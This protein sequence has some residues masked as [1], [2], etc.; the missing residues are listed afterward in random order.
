MDEKLIAVEQLLSLFDARE[1]LLFDSN[2]HIAELLTPHALGAL[3][4][5]F[6]LPHDNVVWNHFDVIDEVLIVQVTVTYVPG[7]D[8]SEFLS[9]VAPS[10]AT[11]APTQVEKT[12]QFGIPL[13][14]AV[15]DKDKLKEWLVR[16]STPNTQPPPPATKEEPQ[17]FNSGI[18]TR[19]QLGQV[20]FFRHL[21]EVKQ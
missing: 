11:D 10:S 4:E 2:L 16:V 9:I 12:I 1:Q 3:V 19:D 13:L 17:Q 21:S 18:L 7:E 5:L 20:L 6:N 14:M 15:G 8:V